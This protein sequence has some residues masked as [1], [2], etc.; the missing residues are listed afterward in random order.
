MLREPADQFRI[1]NNP[2]VGPSMTTS[3]F[4]GT[5]PVDK[6]ITSG[7]ARDPLAIVRG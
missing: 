3:A 2:G 5:N 1:P 7:F 6:P 4:L